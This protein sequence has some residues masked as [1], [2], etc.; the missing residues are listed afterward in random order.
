MLSEG[1]VSDYV[2]AEELLAGQKADFVTADRGYDADYLC[3]AIQSIGAEPVIPAKKNRKAPRAHDKNI[4]K[5]RNQIE[6]MF[7]KMKHFRRFA[8]RYDKLASSF[9]AFSLFISIILW[10]R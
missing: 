4:Y 1:Q 2:K 8:I 9:R 6:R 5:E 10:L 7:N 3:E